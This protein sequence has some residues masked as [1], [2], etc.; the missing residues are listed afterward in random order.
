MTIRH[1]PL[2]TMDLRSRYFMRSPCIVH[3]VFALFVV[4][5]HYIQCLALFAV[6]FGPYVMCSLFAFLRCLRNICRI[7]A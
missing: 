4:S 5:L 7:I 1:L 3:S 6:S 2:F